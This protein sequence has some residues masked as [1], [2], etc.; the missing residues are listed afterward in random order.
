MPSTSLI[1]TTDALSVIRRELARDPHLKSEHSRRGYETDL[2][3][4]NQWR[5]RRPITKTLVEEYA[6]HLQD[7]GHA[8]RSINRALAAIRWWARRMGD[9]AAEDPT[10]DRERRELVISQTTRV[11]TVEGV[12]GKRLPKGRHV[13]N[14][15]LAALMGVCEADR[16]NAGVRDAALIALAWSTGVRRAEITGLALASLEFTSE[17]EGEIVVTGKGDKV[18]KLY[19][20]NGTADALR[21]WLILR[22][23]DPGPLFCPVR[24]NGKVAC[25]HGLSGEALALILEKRRREADG[26]DL[27]WHD[28]RRT[29]AGNLLSAG[30][31][32]A[33]VQQLM[34][35]SSPVTTT[36]YDRRDESAKRKAIQALDVPYTRR[37]IHA[38]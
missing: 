29:F 30:I 38:A 4:F 16:S 17:R 25:R 11:L 22:G 14:A 1:A 21:D 5:G 8:P 37:A 26:K 32:L 20:E 35:H 3:G 2:D 23:A 9:L 36:N 33:T 6:V 10:L 13:A 12:T 31:D 27:T 34:G 24:K 7:T 28:F 19:V 18:R 15:E